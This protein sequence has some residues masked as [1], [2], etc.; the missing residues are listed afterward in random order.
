MGTIL[1]SEADVIAR[2]LSNERVRVVTDQQCVYLE[3]KDINAK[4]HLL[5]YQM[6]E[7]GIEQAVAEFGLCPPQESESNYSI[8][9][10]SR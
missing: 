8:R 6:T 3:L 10:S 2:R 7:F 5:P 4:V 9:T 1:P